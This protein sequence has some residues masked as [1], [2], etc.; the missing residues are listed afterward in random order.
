MFGDLM[1]NLEQQQAE[2]HKKMATI[3]VDVTVEGITITGNATKQISNIAIDP[4]LLEPGNKE[5]LE[6]LILTC[7]NRFIEKAA[8]IEAAEAQKLMQDMLPP[9]F[10]DMFK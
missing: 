3:T 8:K 7:V 2:M 4:E 1:G 10:G 9:G 5:M 6:D